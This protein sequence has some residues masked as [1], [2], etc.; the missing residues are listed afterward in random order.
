MF[1]NDKI[2]F[3]FFLYLKREIRFNPFFFLSIPNVNLRFNQLN[4]Q[5]VEL[6]ARSLG[7]LKRQNKSVLNLNLS[8]NCI[9]DQGTIEL[10]NVCTD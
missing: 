3:V 10:A 8:N 1:Q 2:K 6:I 9:R 4:D 5:S 7:C